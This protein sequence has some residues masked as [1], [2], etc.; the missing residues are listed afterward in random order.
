MRLYRL[1]VVAASALG[2]AFGALA[3]P[4][5]ERPPVTV[6]AGCLVDTASDRPVEL[7]HVRTILASAATLSDSTGLFVLRLTLDPRGDTLV[8]RRIGILEL[9]RPIA[10]TTA[11]TVRLGDVPVADD[12]HALHHVGEIDPPPPDV[13]RRQKVRSQS[14]RITCRQ[15]LRQL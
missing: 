13:I 1:R 14:L 2:V 12:V 6:V 15:S 8:V 4:R 10:A 7:A 3:T 5:G 11:S 9:H